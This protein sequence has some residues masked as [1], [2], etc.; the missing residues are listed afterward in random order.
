MWGLWCF[1][2]CPLLGSLFVV[3]A[4]P[5]CR[6][7]AQSSVSLFLMLQVSP[8]SHAALHWP[9]PSLPPVAVFTTTKPVADGF[10]ARAWQVRT[11]MTS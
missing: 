11:E 9:A 10:V 7:T 2:L 5:Y 4:L 1:F 3:E 8:K 6:Q